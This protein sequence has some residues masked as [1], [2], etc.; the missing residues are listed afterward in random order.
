M[1]QQEVVIKF[2]DGNEKK[3]LQGVSL[4]EIAHSIGPGLK[5][6][7]VAGM[8]NGQLYDM[9][10]S[11]DTDAVIELYDLN[12]SIGL[13]VMRHSTAHVLAQA[14]KRLYGEV[15]FGV[16]PVI[17]NGFYYDFDLEKTMTVH[18][19]STIEK[20]MNKIVTENLE[21]QREE[22]SREEAKEMF[23]HDSFKSRITRSDS[24]K[25]R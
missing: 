5:K 2:P 24:T 19:L 11:I 4:A 12:S 17:E 7:S 16:G 21:I 8:V 9:N 22:V 14:V 15:R 25:K 10:R 1:N 20:E 6:K 23:A 18:D 3:Y 13:E